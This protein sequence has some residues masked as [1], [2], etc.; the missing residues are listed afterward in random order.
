LVEQICQKVIE[1]YRENKLELTL[2]VEEF[3]EK[4]FLHTKKKEIYPDL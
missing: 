1:K 3:M 2:P 4:Y